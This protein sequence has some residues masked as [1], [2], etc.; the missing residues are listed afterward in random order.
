ME[1]WTKTQPNG[2]LQ[3]VSSQVIITSCKHNLLVE[4][5]TIAQLHLRCIFHTCGSQSYFTLVMLHSGTTFHTCGSKSPKIKK[6]QANGQRKW[7]H[8]SMKWN[9][10]ENSSAMHANCRIIIVESRNEINFR[11]DENW[12]QCL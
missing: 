8:N 10:T 3:K 6:Y 1:F 9:A 12:T 11:L 4:K 7:I 5:Q 2:A